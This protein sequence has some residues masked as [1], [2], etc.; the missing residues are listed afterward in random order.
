MPRRRA[1]TAPSD[2]RRRGGRTWPGCDSLAISL[3]MT[4]N[5]LIFTLAVEEPEP[6]KRRLEELNEALADSE[7]RDVRDQALHLLIGRHMEREEYG[8]AEELLG[9]LSD[10]WPYRD[11]PEG[12]AAPPDGPHGGGGGDCGSGT[13]SNAATECYELLVSLQELALRAGELEAGPPPDRPDHRDG[14]AVRHAPGHRPGGAALSRRWRS[15]IGTAPLSALRA[16]V[17]GAEPAL[18]RRRALPPPERRGRNPRGGG[19]SARHGQVHPGGRGALLPPGRS[20]AG[21][22]PGPLRPADGTHR[23]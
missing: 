13:C 7:D 8:R 21:G 5:G 17:E 6:Y 18:G 11:L 23:P 2:G 14:G 16:L 3:S 1:S 4:L 15:G 19:S 20:G 12:R 9:R 22:H 10:R